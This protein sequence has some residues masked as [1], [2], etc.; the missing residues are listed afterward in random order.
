MNFDITI[1]KY[2]KKVKLA[3]IDTGTSIQCIRTRVVYKDILKD[4]ENVV[5]TLINC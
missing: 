3:N 4:V 5:D 2:G 1:L